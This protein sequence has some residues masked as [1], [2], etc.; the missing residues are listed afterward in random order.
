M[1]LIHEIHDI[2]ELQIETNFQCINLVEQ[3]TNSDIFIFRYSH[4]ALVVTFQY[5]FKLK[6]ENVRD[7][8]R[9]T[10]L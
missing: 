5:L 2:F 7:K 3:Y 4:D 9:G 6:S 1:M 8:E 10:K